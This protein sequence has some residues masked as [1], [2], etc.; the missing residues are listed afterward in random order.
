MLLVLVTACANVANLLLSRA[1]DR[2]RDFVIQA[3]LGAGRG[4]LVRELLIEGLLLGAAAGGP[5]LIAASWAVARL[6]DLAPPHVMFAT[7]TAISVDLRVALFG[8]SLALMVG[9]LCNLPPALRALRWF[10]PWRD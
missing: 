3:V 6:V 8:V 5:G 4:R 10:G 2:E 9:V 1:V 7:S